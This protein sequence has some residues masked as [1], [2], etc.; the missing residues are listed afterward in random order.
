[1]AASSNGAGLVYV[2]NPVNPTA[3]V[4][5]ADAIKG[6]VTRV[7]RTS[8][9]PTILIDEAYHHYVED[10]KY[11]TAI[12]MAVDEPRVVVARTFSKI[13][14]MA[15]LRVGYAVAHRDTIAKLERERLGMNVNVFAAT[16]A[17]AASSMCTCDETPPPSP[18]IGNRRF[19]MALVSKASG[20]A[21]MPV[22]G[23]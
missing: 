19:R 5:G 12:P 22:P 13:Y 2:C 8:A 14:G 11:A 3:T 7:L 1:M 6:F 17:L 10:P 9:T 4:H 21:L 16:G 15:G 20:S 18:M 23:P